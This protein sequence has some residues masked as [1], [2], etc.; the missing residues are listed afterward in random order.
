MGPG[1]GCLPQ[2]VT[3][4]NFSSPLLPAAPID[5]PGI[6]FPPIGVAQPKRHCDMMD[7]T[8]ERSLSELWGS[9]LSQNLHSVLC[10]YT[11]DLF[12]ELQMSLANKTFVPEGVIL[13]PPSNASE[14]TDEQDDIHDLGVMEPGK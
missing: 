3:P 13:S 4:D 8:N 7:E 11:R 9:D 10:H 1:I 6:P 2:D 14:L 12:E 5:D